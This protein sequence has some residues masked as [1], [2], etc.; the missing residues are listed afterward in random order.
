MSLRDRCVVTVTAVLASGVLDS[1]LQ[2]HIQRAK[3]NGLST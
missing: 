1:S 2:G 3:D